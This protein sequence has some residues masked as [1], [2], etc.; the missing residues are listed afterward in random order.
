M[1]SSTCGMSM[2][3]GTGFLSTLQIPLLLFR[4]SYL[5]TKNDPFSVISTQKQKGAVSRSK[6]LRKLLDL[7]VNNGLILHLL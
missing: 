5:M 2:V 3:I 4:A 6:I 7:D 1:H